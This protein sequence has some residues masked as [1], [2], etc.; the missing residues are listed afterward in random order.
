MSTPESEAANTG[1]AS[2]DAAALPRAL[3]PEAPAQ[4]DSIVLFYR[5]REL[6]RQRES[7]TGLTMLIIKAVVEAVPL[8]EKLATQL[9]LPLKALKAEVAELREKGVLLGKEDAR[10]AAIRQQ[11]AGRE[12]GKNN[13]T[14]EKDIGSPRAFRPQS[15]RD[16]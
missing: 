8:D 6:A 13:L 5:D 4:R 2:K 15:N 11:F 9:G 14:L 16:R 10:A 3:T 7:A 12:R 1:P